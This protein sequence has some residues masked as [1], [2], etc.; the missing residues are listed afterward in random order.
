MSWFPILNTET[1]THI[2]P[3]MFKK[4]HAYAY[5]TCIRHKHVYTHISSHQYKMHTQ[6]PSKCKL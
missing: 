3:Y 5:Q 6:V 4:K 2:Y 1:H